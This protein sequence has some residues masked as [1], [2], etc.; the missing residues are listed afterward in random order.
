MPRDKFDDWPPLVETEKLNTI[1]MIAEG[2]DA[3]VFK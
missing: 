2:Q 1:K 3:A